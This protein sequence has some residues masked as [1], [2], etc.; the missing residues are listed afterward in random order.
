MRQTRSILSLLLVC[1]PLGAAPTTV[2]LP[3]STN[4]ATQQ[5]IHA[6]AL[7]YAQQVLSAVNQ[8]DTSYVRPLQ[9]TELF[10]AA[11]SGLY[12][13]ARQPVPR[14]LRTEVQQVKT[15]AD[16]INLLVAT[17]RSLGMNPLI[18]GHL[19]VMASCRALTPVLDPHSCV[20]NEEE[21]QRLRHE[22]EVTGLGLELVEN[23]GV[24]PLRIKTVYPGSPAQRAG[25]RPGDVIKQIDKLAVKGMTSAQVMGLIQPAIP[26]AVSMALD[27]TGGEV[28]TEQD[29][30]QSAPLALKIQRPGKEDWTVKLQPETYHAETVLGV[31]REESN[32]W[33]YFLDAKQKIAHVRISSLGKG[34]AAELQTAVQRIKSDGARGLILDLRWCPGGYLAEAVQIAGVFLEDGMIACVKNRGDGEQK[35]MNTTPHECRLLDIPLVVLINGE[36]SGGAELIA[37]ALQDQKRARVAGQRSL[38]KASVQ[39]TLHVHLPGSIM[40][41]TTGTFLRPSGKNLHRFPESKLHDDW[42]VLPDEAL[43]FRLSPERNKQLKEWWEQQ[44]LRPGTSNRLL[45]LDDPKADPQRQIALR[46]LTQLMDRAARR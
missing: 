38:G 37:A 4:T 33:D 21:L 36:T 12:E 26:L 28:E 39:T 30:P 35:Y 24:G 25:L 2:T 45:P 42:G 9:R 31:M 27:G 22:G 17:R 8:I 1:A 6:E 23:V 19:A 29:A 18:Q 11:L 5:Q 16:L 20:V 32:R 44:T 46:G 40:K 43:E 41:L 14:N 15:D 7:N 13:A 3:A 10:Y 34:T